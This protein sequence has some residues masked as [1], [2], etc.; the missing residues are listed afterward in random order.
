VNGIHL[1]GLGTAER[2]IKVEIKKVNLSR[3][4]LIKHQATKTHGV[5]EAQLHYS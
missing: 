2:K 3:A 4:F 1:W 5:V